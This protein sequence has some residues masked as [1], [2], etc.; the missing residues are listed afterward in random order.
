MVSQGFP[1]VTV[2]SG[3]VSG[4]LVQYV[5]A[6]PD[7]SAA[8]FLEYNGSASQVCARRARDQQVFHYAPH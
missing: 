6:G 8:V 2:A 3:P 4:S 1:A 5:R 7:V